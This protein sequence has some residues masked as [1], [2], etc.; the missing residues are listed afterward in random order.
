MATKDEDRSGVLR[1]AARAVLDKRA[2]K[3]EA[4]RLKIPPLVFSSF[5]GKFRKIADAALKHRD[6]GGSRRASG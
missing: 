4:D 5:L 2:R 6:K 1:A 3:R